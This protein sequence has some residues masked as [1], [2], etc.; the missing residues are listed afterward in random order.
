MPNLKGFKN[1]EE[2]NAWYRNYREKNLEKMREYNRNYNKEWRGKYGYHNEKNSKKR[3]PEKQYARGLLQKAVSLGKIIRQNCE[4]CNDP[5]SQ[6]HHDDYFKPLEV[7]WLCR[8]H[9]AEIHKKI[10]NVLTK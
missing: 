7:R 1:K 8:I 4:I 5:K 9:H 6:G 2:R 3:Y 10:R